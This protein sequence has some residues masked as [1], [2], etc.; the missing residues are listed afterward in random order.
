MKIVNLMDI[1]E[2]DDTRIKPRLRQLAE[3][4]N[5][6]VA[7]KGRMLLDLVDHMEARGPVPC[8][9]ANLFGEELRLTRLNDVVEVH[10]SVVWRDYG[11]VRDGYPVM[12][13]LLSYR[14]PGSPLSRQ[15]RAR[16]LSQAELLLLEAFEQVAP[17][18]TRPAEQILADIN[19]FRPV[20]G[21]WR[22][23][24]DLLAEL[25]SVGVP[26]SAFPVLLGIFDRFPDEAYGE[27]VLWSIVFGLESLPGYETILLESAELR[28]TLFKH[29]MVDRLRRASS[30]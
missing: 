17:A 19:A 6:L 29:I 15:G 11:P 24:D 7:R 5:P 1:L 4:A 25:W 18:G 13:Y 26:Q 3:D 23:L 8:V 16:E 20:D 2:T 12:Y 14:R 9:F 27:G 30:A 22:P 28:P 10:V 21:H